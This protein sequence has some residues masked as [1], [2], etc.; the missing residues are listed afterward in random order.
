ML[1]MCIKLSEVPKVLEAVHDSPC[2]GHLAGMLI[3]QKTHRAEYYW[4]T[5]SKEAYEHARKCDSCQR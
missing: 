5:M 4:P 1:R 3:A 2:G